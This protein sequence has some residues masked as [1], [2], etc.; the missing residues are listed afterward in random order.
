MT[1]SILF[2]S[3]TKADTGIKFLRFFIMNNKSWIAKGRLFR[4]QLDSL[5]RFACSLE[6]K[7]IKP[8]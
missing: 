5:L 6:C 4:P 1:I 3:Y 8:L 2:N 7:G